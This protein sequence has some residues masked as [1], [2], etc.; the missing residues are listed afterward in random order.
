MMTTPG[1]IKDL[2]TQLEQG[3]AWPK[4]DIPIALMG[5]GSDIPR[6]RMNLSV[7]WE[8]LEGATVL[9]QG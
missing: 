1:D 9:R 7:P 8:R 3:G 4:S 6:V 5:L 2:M